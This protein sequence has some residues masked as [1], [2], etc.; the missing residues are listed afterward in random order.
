VSIPVSPLSLSLEPLPISLSLSLSLS[1]YPSHVL[2]TPP[3]IISFPLTET[4]LTQMEEAFNTLTTR[5]DVYILLI[6]QSCA[7]EIRHLIDAYDK[8]VPTILEIPSKNFPYDESRDTV[9]QR[10]NK[11]LGRD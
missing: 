7:Q 1:L 11:L 3:P 8:T 5:Q 10:V 2:H 6:N 4:T 9:V